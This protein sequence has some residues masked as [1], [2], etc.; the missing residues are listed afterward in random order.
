MVYQ[1]MHPI[2]PDVSVALYNEDQKQMFRQAIEIMITFDI[3]LK[4]VSPADGF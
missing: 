4:D 1:M 3:K 2:L